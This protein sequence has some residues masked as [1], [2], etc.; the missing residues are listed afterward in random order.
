MTWLLKMVRKSGRLGNIQF[1]KLILGLGLVI[2]FFID[3]TQKYFGS[4]NCDI[5]VVVARSQIATGYG[6][7]RKMLSA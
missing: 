3:E 7:S 4:V 1:N 5:F 6:K 2:Y